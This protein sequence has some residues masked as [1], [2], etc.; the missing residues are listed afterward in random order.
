MRSTGTGTGTGK[1]WTHMARATAAVIVTV[2]VAVAVICALAGFLIPSHCLI[3]D[4]ANANTSVDHLGVQKLVQNGTDI[5]VGDKVVIQL[6]FR[7]PFAKPIPVRIKDRNILGNSGLDIK[8]L[9]YTVPANEESVLSYEPITPLKPGKYT[10]DS[11]EVT[12][13]NPETGMTDT[14]KSNTLEVMVKPKPGSTPPGEE[15]S[16]T[17]IYRCN[18]TNVRYTYSSYSHGSGGGFNIQIGGSSSYTSYLPPGN[19]SHP[20]PNNTNNTSNSNGKPPQNE[21]K[22]AKEAKAKQ[23]WWWLWLVG[24]IPAI[25]AGWYLYSHYLA[26]LRRQPHPENLTISNDDGDRSH[27]YGY[28]EEAR[29]MLADAEELFRDR[30]EKEAY[31]RVSQ[32]IRFYFANKLGIKRELLNTELMSLLSGRDEMD[33]SSYDKVK[34]CLER[35][36]M[37][38]FAGYKP[39]REDFD[40]IVEMAKEV[41]K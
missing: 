27:H 3:A 6:K 37:V 40:A 30:S 29:R 24:L 5:K 32:A 19:V 8:C 22:E 38:E 35:C 12:Y 10:L 11:A 1:R 13:T 34:R 15:Q 25:A 20:H 23:S 26:R 9:E 31:E 17:S 39:D 33:A 16:I 18:G 41:I 2:A 14:V 28:V 21:E 36:S 7:N 4:A